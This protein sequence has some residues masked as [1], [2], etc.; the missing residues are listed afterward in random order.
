MI[1]IGYS[2]G[3]IVIN[4]ALVIAAKS[5]D[6]A[7]RDIYSASTSIL[8]F[9]T[10]H[11][12]MNIDPFLA[13]AGDGPNREFLL[14]FAPKSIFLSELQD[15]FYHSY[16]HPD[17]RAVSFYET[18]PTKVLAQDEEGFWERGGDGELTVDQ[19]GARIRARCIRKEEE[20]GIA[21]E[22]DHSTMVK[23]DRD[24]T[25]GGYRKVFDIVAECVR[26]GRS[27]VEKRLKEAC[28]EK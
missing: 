6:S 17:S 7:L 28:V 19:D 3:G 13:I 22:G 23:F 21:M 12:G 2:L 16:T 5:S 27:V 14:Q 24:D 11:F 4:Q 9:G 26:T 15:K 20:M 1:L 25:T 8:L 10:P 18:Q